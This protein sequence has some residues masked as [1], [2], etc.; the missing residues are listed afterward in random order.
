MI[1][2]IAELE[3]LP[4]EK[5]VK[6]EAA[7]LGSKKHGIRWTEGKARAKAENRQQGQWA[8]EDIDNAA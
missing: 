8:R 1:E 4:W 5:A 7:V 3:A 2:F 6:P